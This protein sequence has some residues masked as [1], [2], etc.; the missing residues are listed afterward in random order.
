MSL[1]RAP[2]RGDPTMPRLLVSVEGQTEETFVRDVLRPHL[3]GFG[4][5][6]VNAR[7]MG[8]VRQRSRRGGVRNW[9]EIMAELLARLAEDRHVVLGQMVDYYGMPTSLDGGWPGRLAASKLPLARRGSAVEAAIAQKVADEMGSSFDRRRF[10]PCVM[11][12]E[13][14]GLLFSDCVALA[15]ALGRPDLAP[16]LQ[17]IRNQFQSPEEINDSPTTAPS[18]RIQDLMPRYEKPLFGSL[19]VRRIGLT[20]I[21][22]ECRH[23][24]SWINRLEEL[25]RGL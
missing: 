12:H 8:N 16:E 13:F 17:A 21:A 5:S 19:A 20:T 14:E 4:F 6:S 11:M 10:V 7:L 2:R 9:P 24:G 23:F 15:Q 22:Q 1:E 25:G 3:E 18:K